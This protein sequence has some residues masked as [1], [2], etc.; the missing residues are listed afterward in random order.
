M[1]SF[2]VRWPPDVN[3]AACRQKAGKVEEIGAD[4]LGNDERS[5]CNA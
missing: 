3:G 4:F 5:R 2:M 1:W